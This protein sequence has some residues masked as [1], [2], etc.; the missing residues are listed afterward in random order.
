MSGKNYNRDLRPNA[1][2]VFGR[3]ADFVI[4]DLKDPYLL[5][6]WVIPRN[7]WFNIYLH[8]TLSDDDDRALHDHPWWNV[9][10]LMKGHL[11][12][13]YGDGKLRYFRRFIPIFRKATAKHRLFLPH[14]RKFAWT[15]FI[16]GPRI[17]DW[18]F[19]CPRG[20]VH[21]KDF[22][23]DNPGEIGRGCGEQDKPANDA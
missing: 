16:T 2:K 12:E 13:V 8:N 7:K 18:G 20:W 22:V 14:N 23:A 17:R 5:R 1:P 21:W 15:L 4:G 9:S 19:H 6:W 3:V 10:I 11:A